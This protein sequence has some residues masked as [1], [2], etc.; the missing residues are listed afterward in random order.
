M[1]KDRLLQFPGKAEANRKTANTL[2]DRALEAE[3]KGQAVE[4]ESLYRKAI[5]LEPTMAEAWVNLGGILYD[6]KKFPEAFEAYQQALEIDPRYARAY[7]NVG[8]CFY[9]FGKFTKALDCYIKALKIDPLY[10][11]AHFNIAS[12]YENLGQ[13]GKAFRH[14][15]LYCQ[16]RKGFKPD[17]SFRHAEQRMQYLKGRLRQPEP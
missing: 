7:Y 3:W 14:W 16:Y 1:G 5:D 2:Y 15:K 8:N 12:I 11:E 6:R 4:A 9:E 10:A 17:S 13:R